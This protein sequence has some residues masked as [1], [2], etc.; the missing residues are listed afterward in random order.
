VSYAVWIGPD[1]HGRWQAGTL[2]F[3]TREQATAYAAGVWAHWP[4]A[5]EYRVIESDDPANCL[6]VDNNLKEIQP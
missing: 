6:I 1:V 5:H 3:P 2:R 4:F